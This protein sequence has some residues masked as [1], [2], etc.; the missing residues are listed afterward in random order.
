MGD[1]AEIKVNVAAEDITRAIEVLEL[2]DDSAL[3]IWFYEDATPG[4]GIP[5][6][7]A[8]LALRVRADEDG[9]DSTVKLRPCRRS[10]L[11]PHWVGVAESADSPLKVEQD[12]SGE[13]RVLAVS[14]KADIAASVASAVADSAVV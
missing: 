10:Q 9:G 1:A 12:W 3:R 7:T 5:L 8:G 11:T 14:A 13:R 6:L 2:D 4:A